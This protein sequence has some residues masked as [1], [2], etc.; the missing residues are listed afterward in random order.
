MA[1]SPCGKASLS[2]GVGEVLPQ[3]VELASW[4]GTC[5]PCRHAVLAMSYHVQTGLPSM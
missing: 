2:P 5:L 4:C 1:R 3:A